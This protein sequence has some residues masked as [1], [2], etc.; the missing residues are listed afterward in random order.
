MVIG[1]CIVKVWIG[2]GMI[3]KPI[4]PFSGLISLGIGC[5]TN[6]VVETLLL[7]PFSIDT[8]NLGVH[9]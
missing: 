7:V 9:I 2:K 5:T 3:S 8:K 6:G 1:T 4:P